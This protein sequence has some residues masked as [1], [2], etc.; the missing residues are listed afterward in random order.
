MAANQNKKKKTPIPESEK[1][2]FNYVPK[3]TV[4]NDMKHYGEMPLRTYEFLRNK[5]VGI[6]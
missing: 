5:L 3:V 4:N 2:S 1:A 6:G